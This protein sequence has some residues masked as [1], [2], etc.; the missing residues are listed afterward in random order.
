MNKNQINFFLHKN[1]VKNYFFK[2]YQNYRVRLFIPLRVSTHNQ[3]DC[4]DIAEILLKIAL[5]TVLLTL[6]PVVK[7][8]QI[9]ADRI[10]REQS[11]KS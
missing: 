8:F 7:G 5:N 4:H 2:F 3:N 6:T 1:S 11:F 9:M 10:I